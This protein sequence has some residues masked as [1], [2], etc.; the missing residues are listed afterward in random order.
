MG[1]VAGLLKA[2][3]AWLG[4][5]ECNDSC[6]LMPRFSGAENF[7]WYCGSRYQKVSQDPKL[8]IE[9]V[10]VIH[11]HGDRAPVML[12][13]S[14]WFESDCVRCSYDSDTGTISS[15]AKKKCSAGDLTVKGY[16]Q[17]HALGRFIKDT[18][19]ELLGKGKAENKEVALRATAS[20]RTHSSLFGLINGISKTDAIKNVCIRENDS[21]LSPASCPR[22]RNFASTRNKRFFSN[23]IRKECEIDPAKIADN[24]WTHLCNEIDMNCDIIGCDEKVIFQH[25]NASSS[26]WHDQ[27]R[28]AQK[29]QKMM[30]ILFGRIAKDLLDILQGNR[31]VHILSAHDGTLSSILIGLATNIYG[32]PPYGSSIF[33]EQWTDSESERFVRVIY[34]DRTCRTTIDEHMNI[35]RDKF[36]AHLDSLKVD[37]EELAHLC[38]EEA[39]DR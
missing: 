14:R 32:R 35:P 27:S 19:G 30:K 37:D 17:M 6:M 21:L 15:C 12:N 36:M 38:T 20:S 24:Y 28:K 34:N 31:Y 9:K 26:S 22:L 8:E 3:G 5:R 1:W 4:G 16:T 13:K 10:I 33:I 25:L 18:Y 2:F 23:L 29:D 7:L 11:R 39:A